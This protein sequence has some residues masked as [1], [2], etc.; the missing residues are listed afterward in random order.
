MPETGH[1]RVPFSEP[2]WARKILQTATS[3]IALIA[4]C[5]SILG[6]GRLKTDR[7]H[8]TLGVF[9]INFLDHYSWEFLCGD[10]VLMYSRFREPRLPQEPI[11]DLQFLSNYRRLFPEALEEGCRRLWDLFQAAATQRHGSMIVVAV[12]AESESERLAQQGTRVGPVVLSAE[13]MRRV[14]GIDGTVI[15]DPEGVCHA[16]G[17]IL[18]GTAVS[19]CTPSRGSRFNSALRMSIRPRIGDWPSS[20]RR[21]GP[22]TSYLC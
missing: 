4:S 1:S 16:V 20:C 17:V 21:I 5:E 3:E 7:K 12:D 8:R 10:Q 14:S 15:V 19:E 13:L 2:R 22:S 11:S 6:L 18:D 9:C